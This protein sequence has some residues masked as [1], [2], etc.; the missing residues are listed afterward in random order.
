MAAIYRALLEEIKP[1]PNLVL[2]HKIMLPPFRK[3][4]LAVSAWFTY[5][6]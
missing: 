2:T 5:R 1:E 4:K 6:K 3:L